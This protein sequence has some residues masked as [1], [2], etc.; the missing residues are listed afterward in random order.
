MSG[1]PWGRTTADTPLRPVHIL[2]AAL[3]GWLGLM[4]IGAVLF[5]SGGMMAALDSGLT[6]IIGI[7]LIYSPLFSWVGL[8][9]GIALHWLAWRRGAGGLIV[10]LAIASVLGM[11]LS[12]MFG[13]L[14]WMLAVP[15]SAIYWVVLRLLSPASFTPSVGAT[16]R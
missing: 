15:V 6:Q 16:S 7:I 10:C 13:P 8:L 3:A 4:A 5:V 1:F 12:N 2:I 11:L 14:A 9:P